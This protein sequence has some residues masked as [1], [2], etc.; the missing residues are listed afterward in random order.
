[1]E[2][3]QILTIHLQAVDQTEAIKQIKHTITELDRSKIEEQKKAIRSGYDMD[4]LPSDLVTYGTDA[5]NFLKEL[6]SQNERMFR[7]TFL[8]MNTGKT[9]QELE[10]NYFQASS[11]AQKHS[12]NLRR[13]DFQQENALM[14]SLPLAQNLITIERQMTSS[15]TG[16]LIPFTGTDWDEISKDNSK[17]YRFIGK[18]WD[19]DT[20]PERGNFDYLMG[21]NVDMDNPEVSAELKRWLK[22]YLRET[23]VDALRLDAVKHISFPFYR[24]LLS[25]IRKETHKKYP[26]VGEY[27]SGDLERLLYYL[28]SVDN[29]MSLFDVALHYNFFNAAQSGTEYDMRQILSKSLVAERPENAVTFV[30]NHDTQ[31]GQ[32]LQSFVDDWFKPLA[33]AVILLRKDG[34]PCVFYADYYGNPSHNRPLVPNLGKLIKLRHSYA[35]GEQEDFFDDG[36]IIGWVRKGNLDHPNS[37]IAVVLSNAEAG[38]KRMQMG[39]EFAGL[40]F[41]DALAYF[42][43]PVIVDADGYGLFPVGERSVSV[44]VQEGALEDLTVNE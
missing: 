25:D 35:Y 11:I 29:E 42:T 14:S 32:S 4:I 34:L 10:T 44:W 24:E 1:M 16:I 36:N 23:K 41:Y 7:I 39:A 27:W 5:K 30:D 6:Q 38:N 21:M 28:D 18:N 13:L 43:D 19:P 37:G 26:A 20:D 17:I 9:P 22:W 3:T 40:P 31:L 15:A 8:V 12:C 2:S 33:Y